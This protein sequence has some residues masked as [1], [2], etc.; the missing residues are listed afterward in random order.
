M[1]T[2][3]T[4]SFKRTAL[5]GVLLLL[6]LAP[7]VANSGRLWQAA[8]CTVC[9][10]TSRAQNFYQTIRFVYSIQHRSEQPRAPK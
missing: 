8:H 6:T 3:H 4:K 5:A 2:G 9:D 10:V 7:A 1:L